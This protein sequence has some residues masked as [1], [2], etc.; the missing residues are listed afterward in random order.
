MLPASDV[1]VANFIA[2][3]FSRQLAPSTASVYVAAISNL[4]VEN[5]LS[6]PCS[7][8]TVTKIIEGYYR[9]RP[10][11]PDKRL[12]ITPELMQH[13][14]KKLARSSLCEH[15]KRAFWCAFTFAYFG[16]LRAGEILTDAMSSGLRP[17]DVQPD[18]NNIVIF[19]AGSKTDQKRLGQRVM[20]RTT[21]SSVCP[22]AAYH[23]YRRSMVSLG[24][25]SGARPMFRRKDGSSISQSMFRTQLRSCLVGI[26]NPQ[27]YNTH[28]FRIGAATS[29]ALR[30]Y[31]S[32]EIKRAGR[33]KSGAYSSYIRTENLV[34]PRL[35]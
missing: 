29:A 20:L 25:Y 13:I 3:L 26:S 23:K 32:D 15:D 34:A 7:S 6:S 18:G 33:W 2:S 14:K 16:F 22:V 12:P 11:Q 19:I 31:H 4:H 1:T 10:T 30:G 28:S 17:N 5:G 24:L 35:F 27:L 8:P 21:H 9:S